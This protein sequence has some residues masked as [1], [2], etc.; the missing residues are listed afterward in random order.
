MTY[1]NYRLKRLKF[2][3]NLNIGNKLNVG[4][5]L[6]VALMLLVSALNIL[7]NQQATAKINSTEQLRAPAALTSA[8]AQANLLKMQAYIRNYLILG[9]S[10]SLADYQQTEQAFRDNLAE[11][12][13]LSASW[14]D[15]A[16]QR[17]LEQF[18][19][20]FDSWQ[21]LPEKLFA[22]HDNPRENQRALRLARLEVRPLALAISSEVSTMIELQRK[23]E[24][25]Q[26]N[27]ELLQDLVDFRFSFD[28]IITNIYAYAASGEPS[29]KLNFTPNLT[30]NA[31][32][33]DNLQ[34]KRDLLTLEQQTS[35]DTITSDR[36]KVLELPFEIFAVVEGNRA[37]ED[38]YLFRTELVPHAN[39][40][41]ALLDEITL[42]QQRQLQ[43]ELSAARQSLVNVQLQMLVGGLIALMIA[44]MFGLIFREM[45]AGPVQRLTQT[46]EQIS[47][48][49]LKALAVVESGD[50]IGTLAT[51][52]NEMTNQLRQ[53]LQESNSLF[54]AA[55]AIL[56]SMELDDI[57][58]NLISH[59]NGLVQADSMILYLVDHE[60][61]QVVVRVE[62]GGIQEQ[63]AK[64]D[65]EELQRGISGMVFTTK[66]PVLS[67]DAYDGIEPEATRVARLNVGI[68]ALIVVPFVTKGMVIGTITALNQMGQRV[69]TSHDVDLLM[70]LTT[71]AAA[72]IENIRLYQFAQQE[73]IERKRAEAALQ[74]ANQDLARAN[75]DK[76]K[77]FS[78]V[79]HDLKGPFMP[80]LGNAELL[81]EMGDI[82]PPA[83]VKE[84]GAS[85]QRTA[86]NTFGL[87]ENLLQW[88][89]LQMGR[90]E[91]QPKQVDIFE[92]AAKSVELL[93][94]NAVI[95][96]IELRNDVNVGTWVYA[97]ENMLDTVIRNLINNA[98]KF[99]PQGGQVR[100][101]A[102]RE[103]GIRNYEL[104]TPNSQF[105]IPNYI[106]VSIADT[107]VGMPPE[108]K[109]KLFKI[110]QQVTTVGTG[111]ETGTGLG[112]IICQEMVIK[113]GGRIWVESELGKG[114]TVRFTVRLDVSD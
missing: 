15:T 79:A 59:F 38:L 21:G 6:L 71:Q 97:D 65:Y 66:Q 7:G 85:I 18:I 68:G 34:N 9:D 82:L 60:Q 90:M 102:S 46:V 57:C 23:R 36:Q 81:T 106:E 61:R 109:Q 4:F 53:T 49:D 73:L 87:L 76:D 20:S 35:L 5:G 100:I 78:I 37:S 67:V 107:G 50:E 39:Q 40:M 16:S 52:F 11:L 99:T 33:W 103:L 1:L 14:T 96:R 113:S 47:Q 89:R 30:F 98:L 24:P 64:L 13:R 43:G 93:S 95:K 74:Q 94:G 31:A 108:V 63:A 86:R 28:A 56:G 110:D 80:L 58:H 29:F 104:P 45:I 26:A 62:Y 55:Q 72:A 22:L 44:L 83:E 48:G 8:R 69:F 91:Y 17:S 25:T 41:L 27:L 77:F 92:I 101:S 19:A 12:K 75:A 51:R 88:A 54:Q 2:F 10:Q 32:A 70:A 114:T 111:K 3:Q 105:L 112:L 84:I 42:N